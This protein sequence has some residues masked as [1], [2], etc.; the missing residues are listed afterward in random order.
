MGRVVGELRVERELRV[1]VRL[2]RSR[3][4]ARDDHLRRRVLGLSLRE[5]GRI[6]EAGRVEERM[7]LVDP[8]VDD[9]D[10]QALARRGERR[11]PEIRRADQPGRAVEQRPVREARPDCRARECA[12]PD[13]LRA[14]DDDGEAVQDDREAARDLCAGDRGLDPCLQRALRGRESA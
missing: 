14:R 11:A 13:E 1:L 2:A 8:V 6:G 4:R 9:P 12:E 7:R 3:E 5:A 10:L